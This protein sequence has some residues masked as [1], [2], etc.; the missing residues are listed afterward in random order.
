MK[1]SIGINLFLFG[2]IIFSILKVFHI[3]D[4]SWFWIIPFVAMWILRFAPLD[5]LDK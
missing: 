1:I 5:I 4:I 3:I 2:S